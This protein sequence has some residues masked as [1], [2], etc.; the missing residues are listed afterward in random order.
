[1]IRNIKQ[2]DDYTQLPSPPTSPRGEEQADRASIMKERYRVDEVPSGCF[3]T[4][5]TE[6]N[7]EE[8]AC[9]RGK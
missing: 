6:Y 8:P 9:S 3:R 4:K 5:H 1:M 7:R 2:K